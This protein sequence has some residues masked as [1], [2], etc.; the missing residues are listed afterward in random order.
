MYYPFTWS[1]NISQLIVLII[2][3][4]I[5]GMLLDNYMFGVTLSTL[6]MLGFNLYQLYKL[7]QWIRQSKKLSPPKVHG[8]WEY[9]YE[10]I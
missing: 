3:A 9:I 7:N 1:K 6:V 8:V 5:L 2:L 10:G 4:L